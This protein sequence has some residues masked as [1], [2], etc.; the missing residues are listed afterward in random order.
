MAKSAAERQKEY[1]KRKIEAGFKR[2][3]VWVPA[4]K[5]DELRVFA[6]TLQK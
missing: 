1:E 2:V 4:D 5:V 3:P 6:E